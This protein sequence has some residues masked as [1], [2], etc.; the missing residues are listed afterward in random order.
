VRWPS[1]SLRAMNTNLD[2]ARLVKDGVGSAYR[3]GVIGAEAAFLQAPWKDMPNWY[4]GA[5]LI[6]CFESAAAACRGVTNNRKR[7]AQVTRLLPF[8]RVR[9]F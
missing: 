1:H 2:E 3:Q 8:K 9:R 6:F 7:T 4:L 5:R